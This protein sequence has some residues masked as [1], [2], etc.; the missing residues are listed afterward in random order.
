MYNTYIYR[1]K[2]RRKKKRRKKKIIKLVSLG[3]QVQGFLCYQITIIR[4]G[5]VFAFFKKNNK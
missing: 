5:F 4:A 2:T 1:H 3:V